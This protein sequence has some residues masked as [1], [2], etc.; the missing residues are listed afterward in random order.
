MFGGVVMN[1]C[2]I[3]FRRSLLAALFVK[4]L[5]VTV[6]LIMGAL[7]FT[8]GTASAQ[9]ACQY[10]FGSNA[11]GAGRIDANYTR[12]NQSSQRCSANIVANEAK[13]SIASKMVTGNNACP[14]VTAAGLVYNPSLFSSKPA[15]ARVCVI[16]HP[17]PVPR[18]PAPA[19]ISS[20]GVVCTATL[21]N[22]PMNVQV[23]RLGNANSCP[24]QPAPALLPLDVVTPTKATLQ[25]LGVPDLPANITVQASAGGQAGALVS[26]DIPPGTPLGVGTLEIGGRLKT[27]LIEAQY[28]V[29]SVFMGDYDGAQWLFVEVTAVN[30]AVPDTIEQLLYRPRDSDTGNA[31]P[32]WGYGATLDATVEKVPALSTWGLV[33]FG[34]LVTATGAALL[35][36]RARIEV[37]SA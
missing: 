14:L 10:E 18:T 24:N 15:A 12:S 1:A 35:R 3:F 23:L 13:D 8:A 29:G 22:F 6:F 16:S 7:A 4:G 28:G 25:F 32:T 11:F 34:L 33:I 5:L 26:L 30:G 20:W 19:S 2:S 37:D 27:A 21:P 9:S 31:L 17:N 36:R